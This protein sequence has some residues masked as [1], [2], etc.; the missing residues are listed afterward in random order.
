[1]IKKINARVTGQKTS[2]GTEVAAGVLVMVD[3]EN[4]RVPLIEFLI[5]AN[6]WV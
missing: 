5:Y 2:N 1:M 6:L 3:G 4:D